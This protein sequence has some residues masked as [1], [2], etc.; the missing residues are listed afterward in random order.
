MKRLFSNGWVFILVMLLATGA[1]ADQKVDPKADCD[2]C[3]Q[4]D[5]DRNI[6]WNAE[7][8]VSSSLRDEE[9]V[10][11]DG[12]FESEIGCGGGCGFSVRFTADTPIFLTGLTLYTQGGTASTA[13]VSIFADPATGIAGPPIDG[14][15]VWESAPMD[16]SSPAGLTQFDIVLDNLVLEAGDYYVVV[17]ENNS[18]FLYIANDLT[19][20][21]LDRNWV[22]SGNGWEMINVAV[23]GDP[24][25]VGNFGI[26]ATYLPQAIDGSYMTVDT[27]NIDFG[28]LQLDDGTVSADV[29]IGNIGLDPFDVTA[30]TI[31]GVDFSTSLVTPVTVLVDSFVVFDVTLTPSAEG[32]AS[33]TYTIT[34]NADNVTEVVVSASAMVYDGL[35]QYLIWNP[36]LS[37][38]GEAFLTELTELGH[39]AA[40]T[41]DL[42]MF[43]N[44]VDVGYSAVFICLGMY[45]VNYLLD[46]N[47]PE[48]A[49]LVA[50]ATAGYPLYMEG[51]DTWAANT[52]TALHQFFGIDGIADGG[53][54]L[55]S[56]EGETFV[57]GIDLSYTGINNDIDHLA[58]LGNDAVIFHTNPSDGEACGIGNLTPGANTIGNSF[59]FGGLNDSIGTVGE[60]LA[61][62][63]EFLALPYTDI[64]AP[65][66][67]GVT[68]NNYTL[69][70]VGPY[71]IEAMAFDNVGLTAVTLYYNVD[72]GAFSPI[73]MTDAGEDHYSAEIPGQ[74]VY[75]SIGYYIMA[76]DE[77]GNE[78][79]AP[80]DAPTETFNL[81]VLPNLPP[82]RA[83]AQGGLERM[84]ELSWIAPTANPGDPLFEGFEDGI[85]TDWT[86]MGTALNPTLHGWRVEASTTAP[87]GGQVA[88]VG[89]GA[90]DEP[91]IDEWLITNTVSIGTL[92]STLSYYHYG[93][94][95][96]FDDEPN[97][98]K[99]S[100]DDGATWDILITYD[101]YGGANPLPA[102]WTLE[103][104]DL[105]AYIGQSVKIAW[106]YTSQWGEWWY[107][108]AVELSTPARVA[109]FDPILPTPQVVIED[110]L[111]YVD[112]N[113]VGVIDYHL[114]SG[115][116]NTLREDDLTGYSIERDGS[117]IATVGIDVTSYTD[118]P[119][120]DD[121]EY[122][123]QIIALYPDGNS[124]SQITCATPLNHNP[125]APT[126]LT[127]IG[128]E[129]YNVF[130]EWADNTEE[131][132]ESYNVFRDDLFIMNVLVPN[133]HFSEVLTEAG[134][135]EYTVT[136]VDNEGGE[137]ANSER[138]RVGT[139]PLPPARVRALSG[140][141]G[142]V[143]VSW[144]APGDE[145]PALVACADELIPALPFTAI[146]S[147]V[148]MG[149][150]FDV[151][152][153]DNEDY[154]YQIWMP[155]DGFIDITLCSDV[156]DYDSKLEIFSADCDTTTGYYDDDNFTCEFLGTSSEI[157]GAALPAGVYIIVVDGFGTN[158][159][160]Y[161]IFVTQSEG[162]GRTLAYD[163][164]AEIQKILASGLNPN[165]LNLSGAPLGLT[166]LE[167]NT[168][169]S[170]ALR[171]LSGFQVKRD[172]TPVGDLLSATT[173]EYLDGYIPNAV[174][175]CY[176][177]EA[178]YTAATTSSD[179]V[180][181]M[182]INH[183]P[184][185]P[186]NL[187][188]S[189]NGES[190]SLEW[191]D[192]NTD[193]DFAGYHVYRNDELAGTVTA[194]LF[195]EAPG[196]GDF[197]YV[198]KTYDTGNMESEASNR[199]QAL[200]GEVPPSDLRADGNFDDHIQLTWR[201]PGN[202]APPLMPCADEDIPSLPFA[203]TGTTVGMGDDFDVSEFGGDS[204]D[205]AYQLF[206]PE[207]GSID[208][209]LCGPNTDYDTRVEIFNAIC[210]G[211][212][213][214]GADYHNDDGPFGSCPESPAPYTP[215]ALLNV[216]L[217]E[218]A[219][220]IVVDGYNY[221]GNTN[222]STG[223]YDISVTPS[224]TSRQITQ[225]NPAHEF[226]K[227]VG[228]GIMTK[229]DAQVAIAGLNSLP[230]SV[231]SFLESPVI[232]NNTRETTD[233][234]HYNVYRMGDMIGTTTEPIYNDAVEE[235]VSYIYYV[236]ATYENGEESGP[237]N[238]VPARAN[239]APGIPSRLR[240]EDTGHTVTLTWRDPLLN[241]DGSACFDLEGL[242]IRRNG[243]LISSVE[244]GARSFTDF[245]L[246]NGHYVYEI[247]TFDEVPNHSAPVTA[248]V[249]VGPKPV[250]VQILTD[251]W[252]R[253]SSWNIY[254]SSTQVVAS[255]A[256]GDLTEG[257]TLYEWTLMLE[258]GVYLF[259]INDSA[260]DGIF[261]PGYYQVVHNGN[262]LV[263][264]GG[265]FDS[266][267]I[268]SFVVEL[269]IL[270]GDLDGDGFLNILDV[271]RFI[272]IVTETGDA[273]T[274]DELS[275]M[276]MNGDGNHNI[277]DVVMLI[278]EVLDTGSLSKDAP[279]I[280]DITA[281]IAP[282]S[283]SN[284]REWQNIPVTVDCFEMVAGFQADLVFDPNV[285]ELGN[286]V[287]AEGNESVG[288]FSSINGNTMRVLGIDL[289]GNMIN[290]A[291][292]LLMNVPVQVIDENASG[293]LD[294]TVEDL[295]I[296]G[297]GGVEIVAQCLVSVI[298][299]G[300]PAP[301]EFSLQQNY[302][303]PFN[304]TTSIR[305][306]I[307]ERGDAHLVI[308]NM[309][310]QEVRSLV[311]GNQ[312]IGRYEVVWNGLD[313]SGQPVATG[314]YIY[315]LQAA[316]YSKTFKMAFIK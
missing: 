190:V 285:V 45:D 147:T 168:D 218:G 9:A 43:G 146:G 110:R 277:L 92:N 49:A 165:N 299:I 10:Y 242:E 112:N 13:L 248:D 276:D 192:V 245:A 256:A 51:G 214:I 159:G 315:H 231:P 312:N 135:Y 65:A 1:F 253:E 181:A 114:P 309:L 180:C 207:D 262:I 251:G 85:P 266:Q 222:P 265:D 75:S 269:T 223:N 185:G 275:L 169:N 37:I 48:V 21:N 204:E 91:I 139:G 93:S 155:E 188:G 106:E 212:G 78:A 178:V 117:E 151:S 89:W 111:N 58:P 144:A 301:T 62:Y 98:L 191:D 289:A 208:I 310:G 215:S 41:T 69:D 122:C 224:V 95:L 154:A 237:T 55:F 16:L 70:V 217:P 26:S 238:T 240:I 210:D 221:D 104:V 32:A 17:W 123:Y 254:N 83:F 22:N 33:G 268:T 136:A 14:T 291:S 142:Q 314:I 236:T 125:A 113:Q 196:D 173:Y 227:L 108:D 287:L 96:S 167:M 36:S 130:L 150:D 230:Q 2:N 243:S 203:A 225:Q 73:V 129:D 74:P 60:L 228:L 119:L 61:D 219:Y 271:A 39:T 160:N 199:Y 201:E 161:E 211:D 255:I 280:E 272:E 164:D 121:V 116:S 38:S 23:G 157:L 252:P 200:V 42:F 303:N 179:P 264:P 306:D 140:L 193:Y 288:V 273:P 174:E 105:T 4:N 281:T 282:M 247:S 279:I 77:A 205:Y 68:P 305:Y 47:M 241:M 311:N 56:V 297:P 171:S 183:A 187:T 97:Y 63:L 71:P 261:S 189:V 86:V 286:P 149:D 216:F 166:Q 19:Q 59:E 30:I 263:G 7:T 64:W 6:N 246:P 197:N 82:L 298:N 27:R 3:P 134:V 202:P 126:A 94:S 115:W 76:T 133:S 250:F 12:T 152:G 294:F 163:R 316:G 127:G 170:D 128:D 52:P 175:Y 244:P 20:N 80:A 53:D 260:N 239:M 81:D 257:A 220:F 235:D 156:T 184:I 29:T 131:D 84:V 172:G 15:A 267:E 232:A 290:L 304:P 28:V 102:T 11:H 234:T 206:M 138:I 162:A 194:S 109:L 274:F 5:S 50:Y 213:R 198:V 259:E 283:L 145:Q 99:I 25:L 67:S 18:G 229:E 141:D 249:W 34:S 46:D 31:D 101:P 66:I 137:S 103:V 40:L 8:V 24:T 57:D 148:G 233:I 313:N 182:P 107:L 44:P 88:K 278:E 120:V 195:S 118:M 158:A 176:T 292:G 296:S 307:A 270:L 293:A 300:L 124:R 295:I 79:F 132:M 54:D 153:L 284:T 302:P 177:V 35:P 143:L 87:E 72:D 308:Y 90:I 100:T 226:T 186:Q 258:P 209:T